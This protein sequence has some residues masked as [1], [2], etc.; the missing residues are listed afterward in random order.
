[1]RRCAEPIEPS[2]FALAVF[3]KHRPP[4]AELV[5]AAQANEPPALLAPLIATHGIAA[6]EIASCD[7]A[8]F[9][10]AQQMVV[11]ETTTVGGETLFL[12]S[13]YSDLTPGAPAALA[14]FAAQSGGGTVVGHVSI[15]GSA[16]FVE[17]TFLGIVSTDTNNDAVLIP[18]LYEPDNAGN[19]ALA[20]LP[21]TQLQTDDSPIHQTIREAL[22]VVDELALRGIRNAGGIDRELTTSAAS[23]Q[24]AGLTSLAKRV[25][26]LAT[27]VRAATIGGTES[28][29]TQWAEAAIALRVATSLPAQ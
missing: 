6:F 2:S 13:T 17:P 1:M 23:L 26:D 29:T 28:A 10:P 9:D 24:R 3:D 16:V 20:A 7:H 19:T 8:F 14:L 27:A 5:S 25:T 21:T 18:H 22:S 15:E 11:C 4:V 12:R